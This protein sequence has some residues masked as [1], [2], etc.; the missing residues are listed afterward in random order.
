VR[1]SY[2]ILVP[3]VGIANE[4]WGNNRPSSTLSNAPRM[5]K[6]P[7]APPLLPSNVPP[8]PPGLP[9]LPA[10]MMISPQLTGYPL[11]QMQQT[12]FV[13]AVPQL[14]S[15]P[16]IGAV[17]TIGSVQ[18]VGAVAQMAPHDQH[19]DPQAQVGDV[20]PALE[21]QQPQSANMS[22][23]PTEWTSAVDSGSSLLL[24]ISASE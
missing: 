3:L 6:I 15:L 1:L 12:P 14:G 5:R 7:T 16:H 18:S 4:G 2:H 23:R 24:S 13:G 21:V 11:G 10:S 17:A 22:V 8:A 20:I 19:Y 9:G